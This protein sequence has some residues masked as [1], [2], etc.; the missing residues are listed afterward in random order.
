MNL[1]PCTK[2]NFVFEKLEEHEINC[3][4]DGKLYSQR[5]LIVIPPEVDLEEAYN[6]WFSEHL[7]EILYYPMPYF[8][9]RIVYRRGIIPPVWLQYITGKTEQGILYRSSY[10]ERM[11]YVR[12]SFEHDHTEQ[13]NYFYTAQKQVTECWNTASAEFKRVWGKYHIRW[14]DANYRKNLKRVQQHNLWS[15][16]VFRAGGILGFY[17]KEISPENWL[18]GIEMIG[19]LIEVCRMKFYG[20]GVCE[21]EIPIFE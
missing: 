7:G 3:Y 16:M 2:L 9:L 14:F 6:S 8:G 11:M 4:K 18:W 10:R 20:L 17:L 13:G 19:D 12:Q 15:K 5:Q 21:R 1:A